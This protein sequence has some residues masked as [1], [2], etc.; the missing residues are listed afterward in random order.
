MV[1]AGKP[2]RC[3]HLQ[4]T[5]TR[6]TEICSAFAACLRR[7][8][9]PEST[10]PTTTKASAPCHVEQ[11]AQWTM[12]MASPAEQVEMQVQ[13]GTPA[14]PTRSRRLRCA[15]FALADKTIPRSTATLQAVV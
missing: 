14:Q 3:L 15:S 8:T 1:A 7:R 12:A 6:K 2:L 11:P 4:P 10:V 5:P 13:G 9:A